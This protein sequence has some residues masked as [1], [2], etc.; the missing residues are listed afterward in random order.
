MADYSGST[1]TLLDW[2]RAQLKL[3]K[4]NETETDTENMIDIYVFGA[5]EMGLDSRVFGSM[6]RGLV[7]ANKYIMLTHKRLS[8][9][10]IGIL[11]RNTINKQDIRDIRVKATRTGIGNLY[12]NKG[13]V[14]VSFRICK[15]SFC[16]IN[17][18]LAANRTSKCLRD[19]IEDLILIVQGLNL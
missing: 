18:H 14:G 5:Q 11:V 12:G 2:M 6:L 16:F 19:R 13:A 7:G 1:P 17:A 8:S 4:Q 10:Y 15:T 3:I 9:I